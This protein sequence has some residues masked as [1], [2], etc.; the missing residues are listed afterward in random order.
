VDICVRRVATRRDHG[1]TDDAATRKMH[2]EFVGARVADRHVLHDP[3]EDPAKVAL[4]IE[5]ART[6]GELSHTIR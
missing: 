1:F 4:L 5:S 3:P 2:A 6:A